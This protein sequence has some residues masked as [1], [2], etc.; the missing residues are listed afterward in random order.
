MAAALTA[1]VSCTDY[2]D[3]NDVPGDANALAQNTLWQNLEQNP[4]LSD[5]MQVLQRADMQSNLSASHFYTI[6][7]PANGSFDLDSVLEC[8]D[9]AVLK[10]FINK[11]TSLLFNI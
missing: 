10:Q 3:W 7:A 4:E 5:F 8:T 6:W 1:A 9:D 11:H 2:S